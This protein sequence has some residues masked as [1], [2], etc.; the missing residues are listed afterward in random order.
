[1]PALEELTARDLML[2]DPVAVTPDQ[3]IAQ[4]DLMMVRQGI[5]GVPVVNERSEL[6]G[7]LTQRDI[8]LSRF[9]VS[10]GGM[11]VRDLMTSPAISVPLNAKL[12]D[13]LRTMFENKVERLPVTD[14]ENHLVGL[15]VH[16]KILRELYAALPDR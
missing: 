4:V 16:D 12:K 5:G 6:V 13:V 11:T 2:P 7:I 8:M 9:F 1:M 15:I 10:V 3:R 14:G